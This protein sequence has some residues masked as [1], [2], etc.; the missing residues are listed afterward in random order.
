[1]TAI[2]YPDRTATSDD[3]R[4]T[5]D[6]RSPHNGTIRHRDG[7]KP[8]DDEFGFKYRDHQSEFRYRLLDNSPRGT[9]DRL[10]HGAGPRVVWERW[11][12]KRED[13]PHEL[14]VSDDGWSV[15]RTHG[16]APEIIAVAP[17][18]TDALR[19]C[20]GESDSGRAEP[21]PDCAP[22]EFY[23]GLDRLSFSTAGNYWSAHS[24]RD[25]FR[26]QGRPHLLWRTSWGQRLVLDLERAVAF[27]SAEVLPAGLAEAATDAERR[28]VLA[29]LG[30]LAGQ[31]DAVRG[32]LSRKADEGSEPDPLLPRV[33]RASAA[34]HLAGVHRL[35]ECVPHLR[36]WESLDVPSSS[37]GSTA[38][39]GRW[40]QRQ[41][42]RPVVHHA[43]K[44]LG[45]EPVGLPAYHFC[46]YTD[47]WKADRLQ[48]PE[49]LSDRR[50]RAARV[51][52]EMPAEE[53]LQLLGSPNFVRKRSRQ[54]GRRYE[55]SEDWE[56]DHRAGSTWTTLRLT[57][58]ESR[59]R[60]HLTAVETVEPYWL[61]SD[62]RE[63]EYLRD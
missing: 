11:Q 51:S 21:A 18:G 52:R 5:L 47:D 23:W 22:T 62:E 10:L 48:M 19:V 53:V 13:S 15:L 4:F 43:L 60:G 57:W 28:G 56:Y 37:T 14:V 63:A 30:G 46:T 27:T 3:G 24:W 41:Y 16:F 35:R 7:R 39:P 36:E 55:W 8:S 49:R 25:F 17:D 2:F 20:V 54:V 45:E 40:L 38:L 34:L 1:M 61:T 44:L 58:E 12:S 6:A 59:K 32:L 31:M 42:F 29:L 9:I 26:W 33:Q 50:D